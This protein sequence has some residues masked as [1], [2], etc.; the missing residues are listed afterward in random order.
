MQVRHLEG[1][2][3]VRE[4]TRVNVLAWRA[5]YDGILPDAVL[6]GRDPDPDEERVRETYEAWREDRDGI[7]VAEE[8]TVHGYAYFRWGEGTKPFVGSDEAGLKE[9]Y[10]RPDQLGPGDR[11]GTARSGARVPPRRPRGSATGDAVGERAAPAF[12]RRT[13]VR[14]NGNGRGGHRRGVVPGD[15]LLP[16]TVRRPPR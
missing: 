13:R 3:D 1:A 4:A 2:A 16:G 9:L 15:C 10:V 8:E 7:L 12:L 6:A 14:A 11:D 5:A